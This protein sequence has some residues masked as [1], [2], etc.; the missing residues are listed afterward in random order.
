M[1]IEAK[2]IDLPIT[3]HEV[4]G[5]GGDYSLF[6]AEQEHTLILLPEAVP[7][8]YTVLEGKRLD[9]DAYTGRFMKLSAKGGEIHSDAS[10]ALWNNLK[11]QLLSANGEVIPGHLYA[12]VVDHLPEPH[13]GFVVHFTSISPEITTF[14]QGLSA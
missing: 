12:K 8:R 11:I 6:L 14:L 9:A 5:I 2:G 1:E 13:P 4:Q 10:V 3:L 7:L